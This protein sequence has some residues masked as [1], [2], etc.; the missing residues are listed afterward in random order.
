MG[1]IK[2][3][4][5]TFASNNIQ[6]INWL[7]NLAAIV[8]FFL[9]SLNSQ[10]LFMWPMYIK[11]LYATALSLLMV[12]NLA[13]HWIKNGYEIK[14]IQ[15]FA[16]DLLS[17]L[18]IAFQSNIAIVFFLIYISSR[19]AVIAIKK[20]SQAKKRSKF[21]YLSQNPAFF[22]ILSFVFTILFGTSLLMLPFS[23]IGE[24]SASFLDALFTSTSATCVTG[25]VVES[26]G[27][28]YSQFGQIVIILLIQ[29]GGLG[30]MTISTA[31]AIILGQKMTMQSESL[32]Q[33]VV[34]E[35]SRLDMMTL[36]KNILLVTILLEVIGAI[37]LYFTFRNSSTNFSP[38]YSSVFHSIS[39]FCNAGFCLNDNSFEDYY[40]NANITLII[41][42]LI[43]LGGLGFSVMMDLK[44]N[45]F[46]RF[47]PS[48]LTAH[49][50]VVVITSILLIAIGFL[51]YFFTEYNST[52][53]D[54]S[55]SERIL[56]SYFQSVTTRTAGFNTI[57][58]GELTDSSYF[59]T[60]LLM[61]IGAS[62]G[63]TG[64]GIKTTALVVLFMTV[65]SIIKNSKEVTV[66]Q[67]RIPTE[68]IKKII[69]LIS[70]SLLVLFILFFLLI[71]LKPDA[72]ST[73]EILYEAISAFGTV[74][75][76]MGIT[77]SLNM[78]SKMIIIILMFFGRV[79]PLTIIY[80][81]S[82]KSKRSTIQYTNATLGIG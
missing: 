76:S 58:N 35:S 50:K 30:I 32:M 41:S 67:R 46:K 31:F 12:L 6:F 54:F 75:L 11:T 17:M 74:G 37:F 81:L 15:S 51:L 34:G 28:Y 40:G 36:V 39:A 73:K 49:S 47:N 3:N 82:R 23:T 22:F 38:I 78:T 72:I 55:P 21:F 1:K 27:N 56:S 66:F 5:R 24:N 70:I 29:I 69:A 61:F 64:G 68:T 48:R 2:L 65:Y 63:S 52:M 71:F 10:Q 13:T 18:L 4:R 57:P 59:I 16:L 26:T 80:A 79:G 53:K 43:I 19:Q 25:L 8:N 20:F 33:N 60:L 44:K 7:L 45:I 14:T 42:S 77:S 9:I 62:P